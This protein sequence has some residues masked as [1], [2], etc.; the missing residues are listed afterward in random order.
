[1]PRQYP[2]D[3]ARHVNSQLRAKKTIP[4]A[5]GVLRVLFEVLY[6]ASLKSEEAEKITCR[7]AYVDRSNPDPDPPERI[8]K[9]RWQPFALDQD[10]S[11]TVRNLVK[12]S[13]AVDPW[14]STLA[15]DTD[16]NGELRIWGL[17][18]QS[19]HYS[20]FAISETDSG[21][22]LPG[23]FQAVIQ[24]VGDIAAYKSYVFLGSLRQD[25]LITRQLGVLQGGPI[26]K[27]LLPN[28]KRLQ[29]LVAKDVGRTQYS[30]RGH[31]NESLEDS[32]LSA[33][34]RILIGIRHYGHGGAI[35]ISHS[36]VALKPKYSL[37]YTRLAES[38]VRRGILLVRHTNSRDVIFTEFL[39]EDA[40]HLPLDLY[41][42]ESVGAAELK[43]TQNEI[44]GCIRFIGSLSRVDGLIWMKHDLSVQGFGVEITSKK[45]PKNVFHSLN[46]TG[47]RVKKID[48]NHYGTRH[49]SMIRHCA[50]NPRSVGFVISQD[51]DVRAITRVGG[52][53][54][55]W[56]DVSLHYSGGR[57]L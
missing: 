29:K 43:D 42:D 54:V 18:D 8:V 13:K 16:S 23:I 38:L 47:T 12:L 27:K 31:W 25:T 15:V 53:V 5:F 41:L 20:T 48:I 1:M 52:K 37:R 55:L 3:L 24:G 22:E 49:R 46:T 35:L 36:G 33:L 50:K 10:V 19:V 39:D 30:L 2:E 4:P 11:F 28:I 51:G 40:D 44:T 14:V 34:C 56:D 32:W 7:I 57:N 9:D 6:F 21:P 26:Y 17:I 45:E